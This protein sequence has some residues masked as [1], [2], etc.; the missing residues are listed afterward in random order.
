VTVDGNRTRNLSITR[1][2][3]YPLGHQA[4]TISLD[5]V[6][7][8]LCSES[9]VDLRESDSYII[10]ASMLCVLDCTNVGSIP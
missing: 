4:L 5:Q 2:S 7:C 9:K 10:V 6:I 3:P 1:L 8:Y